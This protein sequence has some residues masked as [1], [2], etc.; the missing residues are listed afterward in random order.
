MSD[1]D[2]I[3]CRRVIGENADRVGA[4]DLKVRAG[5]EPELLRSEAVVEFEGIRPRTTETERIGSER[6]VGDRNIGDLD[7]ASRL[8]DYG[9]LV[10]EEDGSRR[11]VQVCY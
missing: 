6:V 10:R 7:R 2:V 4:L 3:A 1:S 5:L 8:W 9:D 11:L